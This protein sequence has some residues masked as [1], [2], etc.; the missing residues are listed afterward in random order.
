MPRDVWIFMQEY[1]IGSLPSA[2]MR[3]SIEE[4]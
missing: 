2:L 4:L 3:A 1:H